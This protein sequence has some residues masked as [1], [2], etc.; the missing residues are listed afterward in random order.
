MKK[1]LF[2]ILKMNSHNLQMFAEQESGG[3]EADD[4]AGNPPEDFVG[5]KSQSE[6]DSITNKAI[7]KALENAKKGEEE[8]IREATKNALAK[9]KDY[10]K[11]SEKERS[12]REFEDTKKAFEA[13]KAK[14]EHEKLIVQVEKDL[15]SKGLPTDFAE[16]L[17]VSDAET[18]LDHVSKFETAFN[19]AVN[20]KVKESLRQGTPSLGGKSPQDNYGERLAKQSVRTGGPIV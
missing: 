17:A 15:V 14:F 11:L 8:R 10:A 7:Q 6:L 19:K 3:Q 5:P 13:E 2:K 1:E 16:L 18:A 20:D 4:G 9:E 12:D